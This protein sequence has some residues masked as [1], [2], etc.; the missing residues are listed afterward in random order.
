M[1]LIPM[2]KHQKVLSPFLKPAPH[3]NPASIFEKQIFSSWTSLQDKLNV[4]KYFNG[5]SIPFEKLSVSERNQIKELAEKHLKSY[6]V[7]IT[8]EELKEFESYMN[9]QEQKKGA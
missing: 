6:R 5:E 8:P 3:M 7:K 4:R 2:N 9:S 1:R